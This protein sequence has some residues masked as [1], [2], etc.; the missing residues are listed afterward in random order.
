MAA[1]RYYGKWYLVATSV[2]AVGCI[3]GVCY[4]EEQERR[5][6]RRVVE[7]ELSKQ[8][9]ENLARLEYQRQLAA[10]LM[11]ESKKT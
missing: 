5:R 2:T 6:R 8:Q 7:G 4:N 11:N 9:A 1:K 10:A 3:W